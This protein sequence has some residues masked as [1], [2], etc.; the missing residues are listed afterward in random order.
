MAIHNEEG[1]ICEVNFKEHW[2]A[3]TIEEA[4]RNHLG[5]ML[6][7]AECHGRVTAI[8]T[9]KNGARAHFNHVQKHEGCSKSWCFNGRHTL[10]PDALK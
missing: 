9:G 5:E 6:R 2:I 7:C 10:H 8:K 4:L 3:K 1:D